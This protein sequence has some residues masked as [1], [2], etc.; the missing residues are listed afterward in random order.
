[1]KAVR[2]WL[3][4]GRLPLSGW[5]RWGASLLAVVALLLLLVLGRGLFQDRADTPLF[6]VVVNGEPLVL[7]AE[8]R[9]EFGRDLERLA[10]GL[11]DDV[12]AA[13]R[14]WV[15]ERL[16]T[17][18][19]P[20]EA[21][22]PG[23]LD[24]YYSLTGSYLR[25]G[26]AVAGDLDEWLEAQL[27][28]RLVAASRVEQALVELEADYPRRLARVQRETMQGVAQRLH[29]AY[30]PRQA[31]S[32]AAGQRPV[33][34]HDLDLA[35][36]QALHDGLDAPRWGT[37]SLGGAGIGLLAGRALAQRLGAGAAMQGS[38][39]AVRGLVAR[40]GANAARS[41]ATGGAAAAATAPAGPGA[42]LIG[43]ATTTVALAGV[44][45]SEY[46]LLKAQE[47]LLRPTMQ[48][49]LLDEIAEARQEV[50]RTLDD[51][52]MASTAALAARMTHHAG[53]AEGGAPAPEAYR[54]IERVS[55]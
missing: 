45:G 55:S 25:L 34:A 23:Y 12:T 53:R 52:A 10:A 13:M 6:R 17:A 20:L 36:Q 16:E 42:M 46:A 35:L 29:E 43:A 37:A 24:W 15:D 9:A 50:G 5:R 47:A 38:R 1:M 48:S 8:T 21:A 44:A 26:M 54:I 41:L 3:Q 32:V 28:E 4:P 19:A 40:L 51:V 49:R 31:A 14:P 18:F 7:D 33:H 27:H 2:H 11:Q 22:V 39:L 30:Q